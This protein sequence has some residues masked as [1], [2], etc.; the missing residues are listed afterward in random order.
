MT[1]I[2][3]V[4][5]VEGDIAHIKVG[6]MNVLLWSYHQFEQY[7]K[8]RSALD[9]KSRLDRIKAVAKSTTGHTCENESMVS[10]ASYGG[11]KSVPSGNVH[12]ESSSSSIF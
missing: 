6:T 5:I 7:F 1:I 12:G 4:A 8:N 3:C 11:L 2:L 9:A 10:G